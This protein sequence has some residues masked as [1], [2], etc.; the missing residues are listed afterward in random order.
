MDQHTANC[1][2]RRCD[3]LE[4]NWTEGS[5]CFVPLVLNKFNGIFLNFLQGL[6]IENLSYMDTIVP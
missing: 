1:N 2:G 6:I 3:V 5:G 4:V